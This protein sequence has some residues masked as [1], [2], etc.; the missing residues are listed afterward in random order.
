VSAFD[1]HVH[2]ALN[3]ALE[4]MRAHFESDIAACRDDLLRAAADASRRVEAQA[5]ETASA[6]A[7]R[8]VER[9]LTEWREVATRDAEER[10]RDIDARVRQ[11]EAREHDAEARE[12]DADA[13]RQEA[14]AQQEAIEKT[15]EEL[16]RSFDDERHQG[17]TEAA[18][19]RADAWAA[20]QEAE[21]ITQEAERAKQELEQRLEDAMR[22]EHEVV[23]LNQEVRRLNDALA[24]AARLPRAIE[25]LDQAVSLGEALDGL[26]RFAAAEAGRAIVFLVKGGRL[27]DWRSIGFDGSYER[28]EI[29]TDEAGPFADAM[30]NERGSC[31]GADTPAFAA[32]EEP[33]YAITLPVTVGGVVVAVLYA[34]GPDADKETEPIWPARLDILARYAGRV[35][36]SITIRQAAGLSTA[37]SR[38]TSA[39][40]GHPPAGS[41][42]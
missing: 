21:R 33:R 7:Q 20:R 28:L 42:Q 27:R 41:V 11:A 31:R 17:Q 38:T 1:D 9:Q 13:R 18:A 10:A 34:D 14:Q 24:Q 37:G 36:E 39:V 29:P 35:L 25:Q 12:R 23:G 40:V 26:A 16:R 22:A 6:D 32:S 2:D 19:A 4:G 5:K 30:Q 3:R 15:L 8:D